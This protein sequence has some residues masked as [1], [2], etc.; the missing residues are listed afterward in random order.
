MFSLTFAKRAIVLC[1]SVCVLALA[2][3][4]QTTG[5]LS[6]TIHDTSGAAVAGAKV[7]VSDLTLPKIVR[8]TQRPAQMEL[9][10]SRHYCLERTRS[11]LKRRASRNP[12]NPGL[13]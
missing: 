1:A 2:T 10:R 5:S 8:L 9:F 6:G 13:S 7:T 11:L 3:F 12:S 4:A